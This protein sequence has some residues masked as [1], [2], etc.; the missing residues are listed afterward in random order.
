MIK[1]IKIASHSKVEVSE[2]I[3]GAWRLNEDSEGKSSTRVLNKIQACL[4]S[5][6][7]SFDHADIYGDYTCEEIF[8]SALKLD[9][10]LYSKIQII[11]K[12]N[13]G[14]VSKKRNYFTKHYNSDPS[15]IQSSVENSLINL[16]V[17]KIDVLLLH[18]PDPLMNAESTAKKLDELVDSGKVL[19]IGVSNFSVSQFQLLNFF[20]KN[21]IVT[22]Q[23]EISLVEMKSMYDGTLDDCQKNKIR[24]MAW[25]PTAGGKIF[26]SDD[27]RFERI[28]ET[29]HQLSEKYSTT[30]ESLV[31]AWLLHH[32]VG[33]LPILG[34]NKIDRIKLI[35]KCFDI[36]LEKQDWFQL[37]SAS[38]GTEVP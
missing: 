2:F 30:S 10:S 24:P 7:T 19:S 28:R 8:G 3:F 18:R 35:S 33:I 6:I 15:H 5:G 25:S 16:G 12:C 14:L 4:D 23:M 20:L 31:Y 34:T 27:E 9:T 36:K 22:N 17:E 13:I 26:S 1:K 29:L 21:K 38:T 11:T 37:W 32:P